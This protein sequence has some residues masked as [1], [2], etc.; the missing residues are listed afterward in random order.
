[1]LGHSG[2]PDALN[3]IVD[4]LCY[5]AHGGSGY[6]FTMADVLEMELGDAIWYVERLHENRQAE[7]AAIKRASKGKG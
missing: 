4:A 1:M 7:A 5:V 2:R 6:G 3:E